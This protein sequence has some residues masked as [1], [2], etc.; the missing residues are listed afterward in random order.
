MTDVFT[1]QPGATAAEKASFSAAIF[2]V[3]L[4]FFNTTNLVL[5]SFNGGQYISINNQLLFISLLGGPQVSTT[6]NLLT[7]AGADSG[8]AMAINTLYYIYVSNNLAT[9]AP[10]SVRA[11]LTNPVR[12]DDGASLAAAGNGRNWRFVGWAYTIS[13]AGTPNFADSITRRL[14]VNFYNR[15]RKN[16]GFICPGYVDDDAFTVQNIVSGG[17]AAWAAVNGGANEQA[18]FISNGEDSTEISVQTWTNLTASNGG[19]GVAVDGLNPVLQVGIGASGV[20]EMG[21]ASEKLLLSFGY[22]TLDM[23]AAVDGASTLGI[24][25]DSPRRGAAADPR[26]SGYSASIMA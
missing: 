20:L 12:T 8:A 10:S 6:D 5:D 24:Y 21:A 4:K 11:S 17:A 19:I 15:I 25:W 3:R 26:L 1:S 22:H 18:E 16:I 9:Y 2:Q 13:N 23:V 7:A 14:V